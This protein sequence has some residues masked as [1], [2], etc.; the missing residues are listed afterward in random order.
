L[1]RLALASDFAESNLYTPLTEHYLDLNRSGRIL[2]SGNVSRPGI[3][4]SVWPVV[5]QR[6]NE[7]FQ[8]NGRRQ[9]N[10]LYHLLN[11]PAFR[12]RDNFQKFG[13]RQRRDG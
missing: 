4:L 9:A 6:A 5:L 12:A 2:L 1:T 7:L 3:P 8:E 11:G 13:K 10:V